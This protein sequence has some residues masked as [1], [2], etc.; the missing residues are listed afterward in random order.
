MSGLAVGGLSELRDPGAGT[1]HTGRRSVRGRGFHP[2]VGAL[3]GLP[4]VLLYALC[5]GFGSGVLFIGCAFGVHRENV[6]YRGMG[7]LKDAYERGTLRTAGSRY[8]FRH[9]RLEAT[10]RTRPPC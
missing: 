2:V 10:I 6:L 7:S 1:R 3:V 8:E 5:A 4:V 9:A